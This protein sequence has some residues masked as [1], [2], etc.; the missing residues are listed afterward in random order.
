MKEFSYAAKL[1]GEHYAG[2]INALTEDEVRHQLERMSYTDIVINDVEASKGQILHATAKVTE[3][4][5]Q[6]VDGFNKDFKAVTAPIQTVFD[7][8]DSTKRKEVVLAG[9]KS[10]L[11]T[12]NDLLSEKNGVVNKISM[13]PDHT[14]KM[15]YLIVVEHDA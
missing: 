2:S 9:E 1:N 3:S 12:A 5:N 14:G 10:V 15:H 4:L 13:H 7:G 11:V 8:S 6:M